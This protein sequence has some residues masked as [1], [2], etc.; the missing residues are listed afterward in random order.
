[1]CLSRITKLPVGG[2]KASWATF[3]KW[4]T[5]PTRVRPCHQ[6]TSFCVMLVIIGG[7][8]RRILTPLGVMRT[9]SLVTGDA[10][11]SDSYRYVNHLDSSG[12][13]QVSAATSGKAIACICKGIVS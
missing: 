9:E 12:F 6:G 13:Q 8:Q 11:W 7:I 2:L 3:W 1:M 5:V 4:A 10:P